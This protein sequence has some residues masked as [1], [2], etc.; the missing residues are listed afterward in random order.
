MPGFILKGTH[1]SWLTIKYTEHAI[2]RMKVRRVSKKMVVSAIRTPESRYQD[3]E[4]GATVVVKRFAQRYLVVFFSTKA[5][6]DWVVTMYHASD[7][8]SLISRK[9]RRGAWVE[10]K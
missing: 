9:L 6:D 10:K 7:V 2:F 8:S 1:G 3:L 4:S 5:D